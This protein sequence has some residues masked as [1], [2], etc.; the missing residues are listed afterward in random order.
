MLHVISRFFHHAGCHPLEDSK[1]KSGKPGTMEIVSKPLR[2]LILSKGCSRISEVPFKCFYWRSSGEKRDIFRCHLKRAVDKRTSQ[3][4]GYFSSPF[5]TVS[6]KQV[7]PNALKKST[8]VYTD[9]SKIEDEKKQG[10]YLSK[11]VLKP[12]LP[13]IYDRPLNLDEARL[14]EI[15]KEFESHLIDSFLFCYGEEEL[16][17]KKYSV[18]NAFLNMTQT[19]W[20][21]TTSW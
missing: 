2:K 11:S 8:F 12:G 10:C 17:R 1:C 7:D 4:H 13:P 18:V 5:C 16:N 15:Y 6:E 21:K 14:E 3:H 9:Y 19:I 20:R